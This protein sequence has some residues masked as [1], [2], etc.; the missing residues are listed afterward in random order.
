MTTSTCIL[1]YLAVSVAAWILRLLNRRN[2]R[3]RGK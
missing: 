2:R 1:I 3:T